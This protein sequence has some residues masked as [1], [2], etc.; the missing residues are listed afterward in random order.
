MK[1]YNEKIAPKKNIE[2]ILFSLDRSDDAALE[3]AKKEKF[4]WAHIMPDKHSK[5][6]LSKYKKPYVPY[7]V[8]IDKEGKILAEGKAGILAK[9]QELGEE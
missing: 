9:T 6:G 7:Y 5:S 8:M 2:F 4:P 3:W 1:S